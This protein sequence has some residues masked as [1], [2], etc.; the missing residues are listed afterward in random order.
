MRRQL[1]LQAQLGD[2][3]C[4]CVALLDGVV[5]QAVRYIAT[6]STFLVIVQVSYT[7]QS[8]LPQRFINLVPVAL[9]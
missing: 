7:P 4:R 9:G 6:A 8:R 2:S 3:L 5:G 1:A